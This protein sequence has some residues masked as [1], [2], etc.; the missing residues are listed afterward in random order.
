V[1]AGAGHPL[2][3]E[4][5]PAEA[6]DLVL[7]DQ[8]QPV[9]P[10]DPVQ[11]RLR[12]ISGG[13]VLHRQQRQ[14]RA[15]LWVLLVSHHRSASGLVPRPVIMPAAGPACVGREPLAWE[16]NHR[17]SAKPPVPSC[18]WP[19][20]GASTRAGVAP[21]P[22]AF[23]RT[24]PGAWAAM[25]GERSRRWLLTCLRQGRPAQRISVRL[26]E[27]FPPGEGGVA[28]LA[29]PGAVASVQPHARRADR[30]QGRTVATG[31]PGSSHRPQVPRRLQAGRATPRSVG[32]P[33][34]RG[35]FG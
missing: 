12:V 7:G 29:D 30:G 25:R 31:R 24:L 20:A 34:S 9:V 10:G 8:F 19:T 11:C 2:H 18:T 28:L 35:W 14:R 4:V 15:D 17:T 32:R 33:R 23:D 21:P 27:R 26:G 22:L 3:R 16:G 6:L 5:M 1:L 13:G